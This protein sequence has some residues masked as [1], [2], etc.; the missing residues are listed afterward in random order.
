MSKKGLPLSMIFFQLIIF[1]LLIDCN[2][3]KNEIK[4]LNSREKVSWKCEKMDQALL[5]LKLNIPTNNEIVRVKFQYEICN[6]CDLRDL[7]ILDSTEANFTLDSYYSYKYQVESKS[8]A[9]NLTTII[10]HEFSYSQYEECGVYL[11][12]ING[13]NKC[14]INAFD[15]SQIL[16]SDLYLILAAGIVILLSILSNLILEDSF[17][18]TWFT[19]KLN[20]NKKNNRIQIELDESKK[21]IHSSE[22]GTENG[23]GRVEKI[24]KKQRIHSLDTFRGIS[25]FLM[26]FVNYGSGGY[27]YLAHVP[28]HGNFLMIIL[29]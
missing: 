22:T 19:K 8:L 7:G 1:I 6:Q 20:C 29:S 25:L 4:E 3:D 9:T 14:S 18:K 16:N 5:M 12:E 28:W 17:L 23:Q 21:K 10:C 15:K 2:P 24:T 13:T 27:K 11:M 26:I